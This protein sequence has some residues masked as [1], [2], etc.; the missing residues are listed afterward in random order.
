[1]IVNVLEPMIAAPIHQAFDGRLSEEQRHSIIGDA[2]LRQVGKEAVVD[3]MQKWHFNPAHNQQDKC[4]S[5]LKLLTWVQRFEL[6]LDW[7][8]QII[9]AIPISRTEIDCWYQSHGS[10]REHVDKYYAVPDWLNF[11]YG[12]KDD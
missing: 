9:N 12:D 3:V 4:D 6:G 7:L 10:F 2:L 1:M 5:F 11:I 8:S